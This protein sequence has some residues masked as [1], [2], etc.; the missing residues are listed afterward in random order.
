MKSK[1]AGIRA[2]LQ[3]DPTFARDLLRQAGIVT[4]E[5]KLSGSPG[6]NLPPSGSFTGGYPDLFLDFTVVMRG[7]A[8]V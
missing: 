1:V 8:G 7:T 2:K 3:S 6:G 4:P 5:G